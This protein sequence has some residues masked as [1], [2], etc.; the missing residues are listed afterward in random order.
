MF[1]LYSGYPHTSSDFHVECCVGIQF[2]IQKFLTLE[3]PKSKR[4]RTGNNISNVFTAE[5]FALNLPTEF[6]LFTSDNHSTVQ[7]DN[8]IKIILI[9]RFIVFHAD[10]NLI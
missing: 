3:M 5:L 2:T 4:N 9:L 10:I 6:S 7:W 1:I 8:S